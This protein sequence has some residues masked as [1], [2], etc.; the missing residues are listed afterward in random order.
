M[1]LRTFARLNKLAWDMGART[2]DL[3]ITSLRNQDVTFIARQGIESI[4]ATPGALSAKPPRNQASC[5]LH[6]PEGKPVDVHLKLGE[7]N[8]LDWVSWI[9]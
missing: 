4:S 6:L 2:V 5:V 3:T 8:P 1:L 7:R 9:G